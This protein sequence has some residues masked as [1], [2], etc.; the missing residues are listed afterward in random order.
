VKTVPFGA[1]GENPG[2]EEGSRELRAYVGLNR[3]GKCRTLAWSKTLKAG[4]ADGP[5]GTLVGTFFCFRA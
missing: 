2:G 5:H 3:Q 1:M 4:D